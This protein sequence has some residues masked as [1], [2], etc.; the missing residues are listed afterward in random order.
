MRGA[1]SEAGACFAAGKSLREARRLDDAAAALRQGLASQPENMEARRWL[2][3]TLLAQGNALIRDHPRDAER[4]YREAIAVWPGYFKAISN[5]GEAL[6]E[7]L[8][9][10]EALAMFRTALTLRPADSSTGFSY[11]VALLLAGDMAEGWRQFESRRAMA[12]W[13]YD[14]RHE[15]PQWWEGT[16]VEGRHLLL[17]AEQG[18]GDVMQ[19]ARYAPLLS[20]RGVRVTLEVP[21]AL[22]PLFDAMPGVHAVIALDEPAPGCD[23]AC[24]LMSL[25]LL[26][27]TCADSV[28][29]EPPM[30]RVP[31]D[32][33]GHWNA[34]LAPHGDFRV[35]LV[36][37]G[38][39]GNPND[40]ARSIP[41]ASFAPLVATQGCRFVLL[42]PVPRDR[43]RAAIEAAPALLT[44]GAALR[45]FADTAAIVSQLDLVIA[46]DTCVAHLAAA[47]GRPVWLLLPHRPDWRWMLHRRDT[48][49][50]PTMTLY[51]Q[52]RRGDWATVI[53]TVRHDLAMRFAA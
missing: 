34:W 1:V 36:C 41:F 19:F 28:P 12:V 27:G 46:A 39:A 20:Q 15:L 51:R 37:S 8:R 14:R 49:W 22:R 17:M 29:P 48:P 32:R 42:Q 43:D 4:S 10:P 18:I 23:L 45:D 3:D 16:P 50:Y 24:P 31:Q 13:H 11:A 33:V 47:L 5:L 44:P 53:E 30:L 9:V 52:P 40:A 2:A 26:F 25:P 38:D 35:G 21:H 6:V 7:Q